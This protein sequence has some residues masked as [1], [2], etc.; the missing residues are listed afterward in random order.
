MTQDNTTPAADDVVVVSAQIADERGVLAEGAIATQGN[1][2]L[3]V[4]RFAD[5]TTA[6]AA[7]AALLE[8]ES[9]GALSIDGVLVVYADQKGELHIQKLTDHSTRKGLKWGIVGGV[10]AGIFFPPSILASAVALGVAG[11]AA[12]KLRN[13]YHRAEIADDLERVITPGTSGILALVTAPDAPKVAA[14]MPEAQAVETIPV[15][16]ETAGAIKGV[17]AAAEPPA[18]AAEEA[19]AAGS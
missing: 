4:A 5:T 15:D 11:A 6:E 13:L 17:A 1:H 3:I 19:P 18:A 14:A 12:G 8:G 16:D 7:Y 10:V 9:N 2:A